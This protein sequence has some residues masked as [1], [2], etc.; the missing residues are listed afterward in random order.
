M[1]GGSE[2]D[3][4][5]TKFKHLLFAGYEAKLSL[6]GSNGRTRVLLDVDL[7]AG[8]HAQ[9][10]LNISQRCSRRRGPSYYRRQERRRE[11][12][13]GSQAELKDV[14]TI[15]QEICDNVNCDE[16]V[17]ATSK[18]TVDKI[19][20]IENSEAKEKLTADVHYCKVCDFETN[21]GNA[22]KVHMIKKHSKKTCVIQDKVDEQQVDFTQQ[23][24]K[25]GK[26]ITCFQTYLDLNKDIENSDLKDLEKAIE[27]EKVLEARKAAFG[28]DFK[29]YP[30]WKKW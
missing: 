1:A 9:P 27:K 11:A 8:I 5:L 20:D 4:F 17:K 3:S 16:A 28:P 19:A 25:T 6:D 21:W 26:L 10:N 30:P 7:G 22:V 18:N 13:N 15:S 23:Y 24:W 29:H 2:L 12:R 14:S